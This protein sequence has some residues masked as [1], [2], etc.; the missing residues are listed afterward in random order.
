MGHHQPA[1]LL[2]YLHVPRAGPEGLL[3]WLCPS[4]SCKPGHEPQAQGHCAARAVPSSGLAA[5]ERQEEQRL[6]PGKAHK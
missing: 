2:P 3:H 4:A 6:G 1:G 5:E